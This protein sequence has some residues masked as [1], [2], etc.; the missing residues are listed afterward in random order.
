MS[1]TNVVWM[2]DFI[3]HLT[4]QGMAGLIPWGIVPLNHR[5]SVSGL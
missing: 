3:H 4:P 2:Q 1:D 5:F